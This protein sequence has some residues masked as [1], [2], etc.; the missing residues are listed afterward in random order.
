MLTLLTAALFFLVGTALAGRDRD[1]PFERATYGAIAGGALWL[2]STWLLALTH[3]LSRPWLMARFIVLVIV[4]ALT[5]KRWKTI[6]PPSSWAFI[7]VALWVL[8]ILWRG[9]IIPPVS[10]DALAY[11]LP[12][13][14]LMARAGGYEYF[15]FLIP[16][17]RTLPVNYE[18]LI[19]EVMIWTGT[20][21]LTEWVSVLFFVFFIVASAALSERW[22]G[23]DRCMTA[24]VAM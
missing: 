7:P 20:D 10:H 16:A 24:V 11:H 22:W 18:L 6:R 9:A 19:A 15:P 8:F 13:A 1:G 3:N 12:K 4:A 14:T 17:N 2:G 21:N 5:F 23:P